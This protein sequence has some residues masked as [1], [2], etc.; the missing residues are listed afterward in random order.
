MSKFCI[1]PAKSNGSHIYIPAL[2]LFFIV[3]LGVISCNYKPLLASEYTSISWHPGF[4]E[5]QVEQVS[6]SQKW[7]PP[8]KIDKGALQ[9][10]L[11]NTDHIV[12]ISRGRGNTSRTPRQSIVLH[13][14]VE[15]LVYGTYDDIK[16]LIR[17]SFVGAGKK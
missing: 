13:T 6:P 14:G 3:S 5:V 1:K 12:S 11:I 9:T 17:A 10:I 4:I 15:L 16:K 2:L 8:T 7:V